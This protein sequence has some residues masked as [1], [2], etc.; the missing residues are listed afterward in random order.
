MQVIQCNLDFVHR[1]GYTD[2]ET[3]KKALN[4][5]L[6]N[7]RIEFRTI[8]DTILAH[9]NE[10]LILSEWKEFILHMCLEVEECFSIWNGNVEPSQNFYLKSFI[11]L[12]QFCKGQTTMNQL[13]H[14]LNLAYNIAQE[15]RII[16]NRIE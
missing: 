13:T 3:A 2:N 11:T 14:L 15:F 1:Y 5:I 6:I 12:K 10:Q 9:K 16:Y 4:M 7:R 8:I